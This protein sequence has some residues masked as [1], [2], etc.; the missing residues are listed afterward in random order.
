MKTLKHILEGIFDKGNKKLVG[1]DL[2]IEAIKEK[3]RNRE[4]YCFDERD[5][6]NLDKFKFTK[7]GGKWTVDIDSWITCYPKDGGDVTDGTFKFGRVNRFVVRNA[8]SLKYAPKEVV[9]EVLIYDCPNLKDLKDCPNIVIGNFNVF[10]TG[11]TTLKYFPR[12]IR[13]CVSVF[14]NKELKT[15]K[16]LK[17]TMIDGTVKVIDNGIPSKR[18]DFEEWSFDTHNLHNSFDEKYL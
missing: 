11:I 2:E 15:F 12:I 13:G 14:S 7:R 3:L 8:S 5:Y 10:D 4:N 6:E 17:Q 1:D 9:G 18:Q 16:G